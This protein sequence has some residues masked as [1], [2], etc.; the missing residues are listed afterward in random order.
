[1]PLDDTLLLELG[2]WKEKK[3]VGYSSTTWLHVTYTLV[4]LLYLWLLM[5]L[6]IS[7]FVQFILLH[8]P[9]VAT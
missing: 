2:G 5:F 1:M 6:L 8:F 7:L 4:A 9:C 3:E